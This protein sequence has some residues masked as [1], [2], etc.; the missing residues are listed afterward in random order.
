MTLSPEI[1]ARV[2]ASP[3]QVLGPRCSGWWETDLTLIRRPT[4][5]TMRRVDDLSGHDR[6]WWQPMPAKR[7]TKNEVG[8][9]GRR[10]MTTSGS[11][12]MDFASPGEIYAG[13]IVFKSASALDDTTGFKVL[14]SANGIDRGDGG[15]VG[16]SVSFGNGGSSF[17]DEIITIAG[18]TTDAGG[19]SYSVYRIA[20][21]NGGSDQIAAGPHVVSW[22]EDGGAY[23]LRLD[24]SNLTVSSTGTFKRM[25]GLT[26][27][28]AYVDGILSGFPG[29]ISAMA[30]ANAAVTSGEMD[31]IDAFFKAAWAIS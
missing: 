22:W 14:C 23:K 2:S 3:L 19:G 16:V 5:T 21:L 24:G 1:L 20:W 25:E 28:G 27:I 13:W 15:N 30:T 4:D 6:H 11:R 9:H 29:D 7:P 31:S 17:T 18:G 10:T 8:I 12:H 26:R